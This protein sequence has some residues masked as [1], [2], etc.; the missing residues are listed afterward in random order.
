[1]DQQG[2]GTIE[3]NF[4]QVRK[5]N[6]RQPEPTRTN[7]TR[8]SFSLLCLPPVDKLCHDLSCDSTLSHHGM[9]A[10]HSFFL[11]PVFTHFTSCLTPLQSQ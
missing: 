3:L 2:S 11:L 5:Q 7:L 1:M 10:A 8:S 9:A 4:Q 6:R